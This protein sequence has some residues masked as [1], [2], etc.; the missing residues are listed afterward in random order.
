MRKGLAF[1]V[2]LF[3]LALAAPWRVFGDSPTSVVNAVIGRDTLG[4]TRFTVRFSAA[5]APLGQGTAPLTMACAVPGAGRWVDPQTFVWEFARPLPA[6][7]SCSATLNDGLKDAGGGGVVGTRRFPIDSGGPVPLALLPASGET[8]IEEDQVF[9]A[10]LNGPVDR[11]SIAAGAYCAVEGI[12]E[13]IAVDVLPPRVAEQVLPATQSNWATESFLENAGLPHPLPLAAKARQT[14][15]ANVVALKCRRPLPP[16]HDVALVWGR[17]IRSPGGRVAG[18]DHRYDFKVRKEFSARL[19]CARANANAGCDPIE[20]ISVQFTAPVRRAD[21]MRLRLDIGSGRQLAPKPA[22][23]T[24]PTVEAVSFR[25]PFPPA[26]TA[27]LLMPPNLR[28][29]SGRPLAN[30]RRFP[31]DVEIADAPPLVKFAAPFGILESREGGVLPVTVRSVEPRL[32]G[33]IAAVS[34]AKARINSH[35]DAAIASSVGRQSPHQFG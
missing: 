4:I 31:L 18:V 24:N 12:G 34:G 13:R 10:A 1:V 32:M 3:A 30:A 8:E 2:L 5:V 7:L 16:G 35:D 9:L 15:L 28:D 33:N 17:S 19:T 22:E 26:I 25:T 11:P 23:G 14:A 21:A 27:H 6:G 20:P 29:E